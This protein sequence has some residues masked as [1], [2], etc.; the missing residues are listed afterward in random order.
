VF[1]RVDWGGEDVPSVQIGWAQREP[2]RRSRRASRWV[3]VGELDAV[4]VARENAAEW[5]CYMSR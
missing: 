4:A 2:N 3:A 5:S 1:G